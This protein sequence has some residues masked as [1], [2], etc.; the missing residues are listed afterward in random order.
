M[1]GDRNTEAYTLPCVKIDSQWE[2]AVALRELTP[3]SV[4]T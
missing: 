3:G 2:F 4:T 1:N